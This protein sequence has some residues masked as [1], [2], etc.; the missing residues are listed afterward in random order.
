[1][2]PHRALSCVD[3]RGATSCA[4]VDFVVQSHPTQHECPVDVTEPLARLG[5]SLPLGRIH[6]TYVR[7]MAGVTLVRRRASS[8]IA[9]TGRVASRLVITCNERRSGD[10]ACAASTTKGERCRAIPRWRCPACDRN[11]CANHV[12]RFPDGPICAT[13]KQRLIPLMRRS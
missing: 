11:T 9:N 10:T 13:C 12:V 3:E 2:G 5:Q 1:M 8:V 7:C 4:P 6:R